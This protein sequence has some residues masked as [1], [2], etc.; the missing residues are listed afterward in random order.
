MEACNDS[1]SVSRMC[2]GVG[3]LVGYVRVDRGSESRLSVRAKG[4]VGQFQS[5][6]VSKCSARKQVVRVLAHHVKLNV[7]HEIATES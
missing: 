7:S 3:I 4:A 6:F 2:L 5:V 1:F